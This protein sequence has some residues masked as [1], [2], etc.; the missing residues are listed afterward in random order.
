MK[1]L[2]F[3]SSNEHKRSEIIAI[4]PKNIELVNLT[5][6]NIFEEIPETG[7]TL[8]ANATIKA[9]YVYDRTGLDCFAEDTGLEVFV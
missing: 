8:E 5:D 2:V 4:L 3:A 1:K 6:L 7:D 9:K